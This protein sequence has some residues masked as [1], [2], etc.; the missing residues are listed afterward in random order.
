MQCQFLVICIFY[1]LCS[2]SIFVLQL[3]VL[4]PKTRVKL[5]YPIALMTSGVLSWKGIALSPV[6]SAVSILQLIYFGV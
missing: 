4:I 2:I 3:L 6:E 5:T 1:F